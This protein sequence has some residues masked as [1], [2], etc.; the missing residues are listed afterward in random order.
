MFSQEEDL[1]GF[2]EESKQY[3]R[4]YMHDIDDFHKEIQLISRDIILYKGNIHVNQP[5]NSLQTDDKNKTNPKE[6]VSCKE[7]ANKGEKKKEVR[8]P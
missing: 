8:P 6:R 4:G 1:K 5:S 7:H 3:Q 2:E